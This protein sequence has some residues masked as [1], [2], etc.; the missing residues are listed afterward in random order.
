MSLLQINFQIY[1]ILL[2]RMGVKR[3]HI[4]SINPADGYNT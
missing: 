1:G 4:Y 2:F 3:I